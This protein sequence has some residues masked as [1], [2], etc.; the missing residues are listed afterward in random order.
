MET[1]QDRV[2]ASARAVLPATERRRTDLTTHGFTFV[3]DE[4]HNGAL[5][6]GPTPTEYLLMALASCTAQTLRQYVDYK[7]DTAG[8]ITSRSTTT[9][10]SRK[11]RSATCSARS[12]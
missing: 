1:N 7:Y 4:P 10:P 11:A 8:D 9:N 12:R 3:A 5:G 6:D 2:V